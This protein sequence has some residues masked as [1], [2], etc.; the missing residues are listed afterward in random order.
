MAQERSPLRVSLVAVPEA[1]SFTLNG[2]YEVLG[3]FALLG[4]HDMALP[5]TPPFSVEVVALARGL[6]PTASG[7]PIMAHAAIDEVARTDLVIVPSVMV[8]GGEWAVGRHPRMVQWLKDMHAR[9]AILCSACSGLLL[10]AETG[11]LSGREA[12]MHW[13]YEPTFRRNFPDVRLRLEEVL[14]TAGARRE[15]VMSGAAMAWHDL[16]LHLIARHV[17][18]AAAQSIARFFAMRWHDDGQAPYVA[19]VPL[20]AHGDAVVADAQVWLERNF[21]V[22]S[23]VEELVRRSGVPERSFKRRFTQATGIPPIAYVQRVRIEYAKR[24]LEQS[25]M[26][27]EEVSWDVG[28]ADAASFRRL[29][30]RVTGIAPGAYRRRYRVPVVPGAPAA[31]ALAMARR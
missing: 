27:V 29:F 9:G 13:A 15:F 21:A 20:A 6:T 18:Q 28:Y 30:R 7:L 26:P 22:A 19:F 5:R 17:G 1:M 16:V 14:V 25:D 10:L 8:E 31:P 4:T 23:P 24:R 3:S 11:L 12:T 2:L